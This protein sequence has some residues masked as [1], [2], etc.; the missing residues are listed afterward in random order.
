M[1][2]HQNAHGTEIILNENGQN[3]VWVKHYKSITQ[4][5]VVVSYFVPV[6]QNCSM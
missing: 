4:L 1:V 6:L 2:L 5:F 3:I